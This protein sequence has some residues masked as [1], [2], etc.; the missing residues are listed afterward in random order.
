MRSEAELQ[1]RKL[2]HKLAND[3]TVVQGSLQKAI[4]DGEKGELNLIKLHKAHDHLKQSI[5]L[6]SNMRS[7]IHS[8]GHGQTAR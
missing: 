1:L 7:L 2:L 4:M 6:I 8:D 3:V 5:A